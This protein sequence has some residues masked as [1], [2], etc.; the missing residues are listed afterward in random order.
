MNALTNW[1]GYRTILRKETVRIFRIWP[2][3]ILPSVITQ[4][5]YFLIFGNFIGSQLSLIAGGNY[6]AF[7]VPGLI[8]MSSITSAFSNTASSFFGSKFMRSIEELLVSPLQSWTIL[9]GYI[10][11]GMI[12]GIVVALAV[13]LVSLLFAPI[14]IM[15]IFTLLFFLIITCMIF[16][17]L[18]FLNGLFAKKFDDVSLIPTFVLTPLTYLGGVFYDINQ[19]PSFWRAISYFNPIVFMIDGLRYGFS[20]VSSTPVYASALI[21]LVV[22]F[23]LAFISIGLIKKGIGLKT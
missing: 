18:G 12:R 10:S 19:L 11:G 15:H 17:L 14:E 8:M 23:I 20:G 22:A 5:L 6:S 2:Q 4:F 9:A 13:F 16:S 1:I 3:T 7:L 21:L